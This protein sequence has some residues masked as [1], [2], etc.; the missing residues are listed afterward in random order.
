MPLVVYSFKTNLKTFLQNGKILREIRSSYVGS[1]VS[2]TTYFISLDA[3]LICLL[4]PV[5]ADG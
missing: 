2:S 1:V 3:P 4:V 5:E